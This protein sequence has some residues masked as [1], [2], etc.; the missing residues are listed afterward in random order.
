MSE[1][2]LAVYCITVSI[3]ISSQDLGFITSSHLIQPLTQKNKQS[4]NNKKAPTK[5]KQPP[6]NQNTYVRSLANN[7]CTPVFS[8]MKQD[9]DNYIHYLL[10][11]P[12][13][14][15]WDFQNEMSVEINCMG[16]IFRNILQGNGKQNSLILEIK[17]VLSMFSSN[18]DHD[19]LGMYT[20]PFSPWLLY[21]SGHTDNK[22]NGKCR[23]TDDMRMC[24]KQSYCI[25]CLCHFLAYMCLYR[26]QRLFQSWK[27]CCC[28]F[29]VLSFSCSA[30]ANRDKKVVH[31][32]K[33]KLIPS[34]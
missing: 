28:Y 27:R 34:I 26:N 33:K 31:F 32:G 24:L 30:G 18:L 25:H 20:F 9:G 17:P 2:I 15:I 1:F 10:V 12:N 16:M 7:P 8:F 11:L 19:S 14:G 3:F 21:S 6:R 5:Q 13:N 23:V 22:L 29:I 4:T